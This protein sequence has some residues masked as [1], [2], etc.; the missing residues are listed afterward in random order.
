MTSESLSDLSAAVEPWAPIAAGAALVVA[1]VDAF[2]AHRTDKR[3]SLGSL[4]VRPEW[5]RYSLPLRTLQPETG[6]GRVTGAKAGVGT[7]ITL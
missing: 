2:M 5:A 6:T 7:A 4:T 1:A 3:C